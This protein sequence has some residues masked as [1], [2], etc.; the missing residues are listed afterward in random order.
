[1][2]RVNKNHVT[3][4]AGRDRDQPAQSETSQH[5]TVVQHGKKIKGPIPAFDR[6]DKG[7]TLNIHLRR[8]D[9]DFSFLVIPIFTGIYCFLYTEYPDGLARKNLPRMTKEE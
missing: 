3:P 6:C 5:P 7:K 8:H 4:I 9:D 2:T 1:M